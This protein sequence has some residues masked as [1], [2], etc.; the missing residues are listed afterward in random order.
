MYTACTAY[1]DTIHMYTPQKI[2]KSPILFEYFLFFQNFMFY[3]SIS[4]TQKT[5]VITFTRKGNAKTSIANS[6]KSWKG[7]MCQ[8]GETPW[9]MVR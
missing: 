2:M 9:G 1:V 5:Q 8:K 7:S 6:V 3:N 4:I